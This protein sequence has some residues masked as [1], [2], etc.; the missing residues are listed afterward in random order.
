MLPSRSREL[1][2]AAT[3]AL[4]GFAQFAN[5]AAAQI[6]AAMARPQFSTFDRE[7]RAAAYRALGK[8][9]S[10]SG[11]SFLVDRLARPARGLFRRRKVD[12]DQL[13]AVQGL[14]EEASQRS[15]RALEDALLPSY[16]H[17]A[18][19]TAACRAAAQHVRMSVRGG[20]SA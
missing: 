5:V 3:L 10:A 4:G 14:A 9:A 11:F 12:A 2:L 7:E 16:K 17:G 19:V 13:L 18:A 20:K 6:M 1:R 8:L 15:L